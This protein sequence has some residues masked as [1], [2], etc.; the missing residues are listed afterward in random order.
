MSQF[1]TQNRFDQCFKIMWN[2]VCVLIIQAGF[3]SLLY[4][5]LIDVSIRITNHTWHLVIRLVNAFD[6][7]NHLGTKLFNADGHCILNTTE[8]AFRDKARVK[9]SCSIL[10]EMVK[11]KNLCNQGQV[12]FDMFVLK[13]HLLNLYPKQVEIDVKYVRF[14]H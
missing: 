7:W 11:S 12:T 4:L 1:A 14:C 9:D 3:A 13:L 6:D 5:K 2:V 8:G 10:K